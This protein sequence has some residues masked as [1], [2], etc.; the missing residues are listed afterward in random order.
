MHCEEGWADCAYRVVSCPRC[1]DG[2]L[3]GMVCG[4]LRSANVVV[5][6]ITVAKHVVESILPESGS[7][8]GYCNKTTGR[9]HC[10]RAW[11]GADCLKPLCGAHGIML[12]DGSCRGDSGWYPPSSAVRARGRLCRPDIHCVADKSITI[13]ATKGQLVAAR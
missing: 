12:P 10:R 8:S 6:M 1:D 7:S 2:A 13:L 11:T 3:V 5:I 9:C 4:I